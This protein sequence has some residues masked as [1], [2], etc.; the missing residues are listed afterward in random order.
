MQFGLSLPNVG[1]PARLVELA[2]AAE[3]SGWDGFFLWDH[4]VLD[5]KEPFELVDPWVV[6]GAIAARTSRI[7]LGT[8]VTPIAR[9]RPWKLAKEITTLDHLSGG[10][11]ILGVG[12]GAPTE[13]FANFGEEAGGRIRAARLDEGLDLLDAFLRGDQ[14]DHDGEQFTVHARLR[15]AARQRPR[16]LIW[17]AAV[18][19]N[20]RPIVR[21]RRW[22]GLFALDPNPD[23]DGSLTPQTVA[24]LA[25]ELGQGH[26]IVTVLRSDKDPEEYAAAGATWGIDGPEWPE[27]D[28][29][30][31]GGAERIRQGPPKSALTPGTS[32]RSTRS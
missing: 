22:D 27:P 8:L 25:A 7:K 16:P 31:P 29:P 19:P 30:W 4:L 26:D 28:D 13:E 11:V 3:A 32:S 12:L 15:P 24:Q 5:P 21:A 1:D 20:R 14:V 10:R 6:L 18:L 9:R 17:V 2:A 23:G